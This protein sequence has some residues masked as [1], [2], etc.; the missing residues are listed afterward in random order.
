MDPCGTPGGR[1]L[2]ISWTE[3]IFTIVIRNGNIIWKN[4]PHL[5][6]F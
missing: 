6:E 3:L 2:K 5:A 4:G 1:I